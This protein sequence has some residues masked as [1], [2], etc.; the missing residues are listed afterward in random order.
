M[1]TARLLDVESS[2][3]SR[4]LSELLDVRLMATL[5]RL[6]QLQGPIDCTFTNQPLAIGAQ[7]P[8][9]SVGSFASIRRRDDSEMDR[10]TFIG[11][12]ASALLAAPLVVEAQPAKR[13]ARIGFIGAWYSPSAAAI[14]FEAFRRGMRELG[15]VEGQNLSI[16]TRW[17][18]EGESVRDGAA[19]A[20]V[21]LIGS[22][23][24]V[25]VVQGTAIDGVKDEAES[26]PVVFG[27]SGDPVEAKLVTSLARP[28]GN[29]TG[30][31]LLALE[32]AG[33]QL[34]LLKEVV[35]NLSR[36]AVIVN[37]LHAGEDAEFQSSQIAAQRLGLA[38]QYFPVRT[39]ADVNAALEAIARD[40][41]QA[42]LAF[43]NLL[44]YRQRNAIAQFAATQR[45][46]TM[47]G[48]ADFAVDGNLMTYGPD[49]EESWRFIATYVDKILKGTKPAELPV[50][51][52]TKFELVI[53]LKTAKILGLTI[54][55]SLLLR[56]DKVIQ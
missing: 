17:V 39:V 27:Y 31:T 12:V 38:L 49:L 56:A 44:I 5:G 51:Q 37:P 35:P 30:M 53:N 23:V 24:E 50:V 13:V 26:V 43:P 28:G 11:S 2:I 33:K 42:I 19:K 22:K 54:P 8:R 46:P 29:F 3:Y 41:D 47:S 14:L 25:L 40:R 1:R 34:Q 18:G 9:V 36:V 20:A 16:D 10:R 15:Y 21:E 48:W 45:I 52:P 7:I 4:N 6:T 32:V 55:P